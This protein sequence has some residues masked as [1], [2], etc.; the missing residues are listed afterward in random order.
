SERREHALALLMAK[1]C[2][3]VSQQHDGPSWL[4]TAEKDGTGMRLVCVEH[5]RLAI[6]RGQWQDA[7]LHV[8]R[9]YRDNEAWLAD[10]H[11]CIALCVGVDYLRDMIA[12]GKV[13]DAQAFSSRLLQRSVERD[14]AHGLMVHLATTSASL[15]E[16]ISV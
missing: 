14:I 11:N 8:K 6:A 10:A 1:A 12:L 7:L 16:K 15:I 5:A 3:E 13:V 4:A 2:R 9:A